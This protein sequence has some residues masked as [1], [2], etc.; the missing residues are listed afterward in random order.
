MA[1][2]GERLGREERVVL[3][4]VFGSFV[5]SDVA[6][7]VDVGVYLLGGDWLEDAI[8]VDELGEELSELVGMPVDVVALNH[9]DEGVLARAIRGVPVVVRDQRLYTGL[10]MLGM[11]VMNRW[12]YGRIC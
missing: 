5:S 4:V 6:R 9:V 7:D 1:S 8:Y 12:V 11:E 2:I 3:A 10:L